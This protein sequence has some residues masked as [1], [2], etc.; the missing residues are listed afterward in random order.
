MTGLP[1]SGSIFHHNSL[2]RKE[3]LPTAFV[4][5]RSV[6]RIVNNADRLE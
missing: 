1:K 5:F 3:S 2:V 4:A 6:C